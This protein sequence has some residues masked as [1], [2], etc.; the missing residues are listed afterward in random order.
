MQQGHSDGAAPGTRFEGEDV[1][2][3]VKATEQDG[4]YPR[5]LMLREQWTSLDGPWEFASDDADRGLAERWYATPDGAAGVFGE[6]I[7]VPFPPESAASGLAHRD[8]HPVV[9]YRRTFSLGDV[10]PQGL[11]GRR[12]LVHFGAVDFSAQVWC[13]GRLVVAHV[14]GQTPFTADVT[15]V[16]DEG[17]E[18]HVLVVRAEDDPLD[19]D[20][21]RG[22]QDWRERPHGIWYDRTTGIWQSVWAECVGEDRIV[23]LA[24]TTD[25]GHGIGGEITLARPPA[26]PAVVEVTVSLGEELLAEQSTLAAGRT[27]RLDVAVDALRNGQ[28]RARL[29]WSP[30]Q[31][32]LVDVAVRLRDRASGDLLDEVASYTG[33][34][35]VSVDHGVFRLNEQPYYMRSVLNQGFRPETHLAARDTTELR[36]EVETIKALGFNSVRLHQKCEDPRW[37]YWADRLGLMVWGESASPY[38]YSTTAVTRFVAE[39][40]DIVRRYRSHPALVVWVPINESWGVQDIALDPAQQAY[41]QALAQLTRGLD[42]SRPVVSN[43][44]WEHVDSDILGLH[45]YSAAEEMQARYADREALTEVV[46]GARTPH[47]R[48]PVLSEAQERGFLTGETPVMITE[49]GGISFARGEGD[50]DSWGY[51]TVTTDEEYAHVLRAQFDALR[52]S[53]DV[54]GLCY[55]QYMDTGQETNGLLLSDGTPKLPVEVIR[56]IVTGQAGDGRSVATSTMGWV[57]E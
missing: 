51:S 12:L 8:F 1:N 40:T 33:L 49:F 52:A 57:D 29:L 17:A 19:P 39:W 45:D 21:A 37:L 38:A 11:D 56:E 31:P 14:G 6:R 47:G 5:P 13:D 2:A 22:K 35:A 32:T 10:A 50:E 20:Q 41:S 25:P 44:G 36:T 43:E 34:R 46:L 42:P 7:E 53:R 54:V 18:R 9:W 27:I 28:D 48:R 26:R 24:W 15:D 55:T 30:E 4:S 3:I 16:L 23:D